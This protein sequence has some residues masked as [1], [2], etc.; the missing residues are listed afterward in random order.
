MLRNRFARLRAH[1]KRWRAW[2][3]RRSV[4]DD[5]VEALLSI[6]PLAFTAGLFAPMLPYA[7]PKRDDYG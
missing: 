7:A 6:T 3:R 2:R 5:P 1:G 4:D